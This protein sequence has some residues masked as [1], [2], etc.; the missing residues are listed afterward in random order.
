MSGQAGNIQGRIQAGGNPFEGPRARGYPLPPLKRSAATVEVRPG[1]EGSR[2]QAVSLRRRQYV[3]AIQE[4][5][6]AC[7]WASARIA[8]TA[9]GLPAATTRSRRPQTTI[10]PVLL[11]KA[12]FSYRTLCDVTRVNLD[13]SGQARHRRHLC[14]HRRDANSSSRPSW[15]ILCAYAQHNVHLLLALE[16]RPAVRPQARTAASSAQLRL[17]DH[18]VGQRLHRRD[19]ESVHGRGRAR[20][21]DRRVQRRQFRPW[22]ARIH[23]RRLH[24][25]V[26]DRRTADP[27]AARRAGGTPKWGAGWKK[28]M[29]ENYLRSASIA[30][31]GSVMSYRDCLSRPRSDL[32][33]HLRQSAAAADFRFPR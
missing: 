12:N 4:P 26:D 22:S 2:L 5:A 25:P 18:L 15:S 6:T 21:G 24:R 32:S 16:D 29:H 8:V 20:A 7:R 10:L 23:R 13:S 3:E 30:T 28:A 9:S 31:H 14:R 19:H 27:A 17:S 11:R 1:G 33:R